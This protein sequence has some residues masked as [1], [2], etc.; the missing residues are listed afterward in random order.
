[1]R[2]SGHAGPGLPTPGAQCIGTH[3]F[4]IAF[5]PRAEPPAASALFGRAASFV[6]PPH[7]VPASGAGGSLPMTDAFVR[8]DRPRGAVVLSAC[9]RAVER[10]SL[11]LRVFNPDETPA[12]VRLGMRGPIRQAFRVDLLENR[13]AE[14]AVRNGVIDVPVGPHQIA[15]VE[16]V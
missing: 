14:L 9:G 2:P 3:G 11:L 1:M 7:V 15:T 8:F 5:E 12:T 16:F 10:E 13:I 4:R 6:A